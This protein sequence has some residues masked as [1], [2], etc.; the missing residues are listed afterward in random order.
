MQGTAMQVPD[1]DPGAVAALAAR[2]PGLRLVVTGAMGNQIRATAGG[3]PGEARVWFDVSRVQGPIDALR[4]LC[5]EVGRGACCSAR[6]S[7]CTSPP[8]RCWRSR[9]PSPPGCRKGTQG[10][11]ATPTRG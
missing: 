10:P 11:S 8:R 3:L 2:R 4:S 6:T 5:R 9:T 7:P 1:L